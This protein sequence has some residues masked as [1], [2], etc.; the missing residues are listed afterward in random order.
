[1]A[2]NRVHCLKWLK[3]HHHWV[4]ISTL[5]FYKL[6][7]LQ[8]VKLEVFATKLRWT[9]DNMSL[10]LGMMTFNVPP[11]F[12][13]LILYLLATAIFKTHAKW[14]PSFRTCYFSTLFAPQTQPQWSSWLPLHN[15]MVQRLYVH[16]VMLLMI[17]SL[18][19]TKTWIKEKKSIAVS[20]LH[21]S[22]LCSKR[23]WAI[24]I[25]LYI[26]YLLF[27]FPKKTTRALL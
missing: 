2:I 24:L 25:I 3:H 15:I 27:F 19:N 16:P 7:N 22:K 11:N 5:I 14:F 20:L 13:S 17:S 4:S 1:M 10:I 26:L 6:I 12:C 8:V 9:S 21:T 18:L 23:F